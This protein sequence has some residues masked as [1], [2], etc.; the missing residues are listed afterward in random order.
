MVQNKIRDKLCEAGTENYI[1]DIVASSLVK[2]SSRGVHS[3][4]IALI[5]RYLYEIKNKIL[6]PNVKP[7]TE[8]NRS[9]FAVSATLNEYKG[10][11][12]L[13][14]L[15][16]CHKSLKLA[17]SNVSLISISITKCNHIG[18][19]KQYASIFNKEEFSFIGIASAGPNVGLDDGKKV[20]TNPICITVP[21]DLGNGEYV[22]CDVATSVYPEGKVRVSKMNNSILP[23][24][25]IK[26]SK[27]RDSKTPSDLYEGGWLLPFGGYKG[28]SLGSS[29]DIFLGAIGGTSNVAGWSWGNNAQFFAIR[30]SFNKIPTKVDIENYLGNNIPALRE[31]ITELES[32]KNGIQVDSETEKLLGLNQ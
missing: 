15:D 3:H 13:G 18:D 21:V 10:F 20:G 26:D 17:D 1:G 5:N 2:A 4:G 9:G 8:V 16:A 7:N 32:N 28:F 24:G 27:G 23:H 14:V 6:V 25:I 31:K 19:L 29:I 22:G 12:Q 11:G 30:S